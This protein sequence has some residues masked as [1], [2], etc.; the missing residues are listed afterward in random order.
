MSDQV[1]KLLMGTYFYP[2]GGSAHVARALAGELGAQGIE[3]TLVSGSRAD[4]GPAADA[5]DFYA[6]LDVRAV[7]FTPA[8][9]SGRPL[10]FVGPAGTA[11]MHGSFED[12]ED[13]VD[14]V[15]TSLDDRRLELQV[16]AWARELERAAAGGVDRL[17][18]H[19]LTPLN[20]AA[21]R[22]LPG[23]PIVGHIP[24]T[25]LLMLAAIQAG[26]G[27]GGRG[28]VAWIKRLRRW[29]AACERLIVADR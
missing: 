24:G 12:R 8:L 25:Q 23:V 22:A 5:K 28:G 17:Y 11:P 4:L 13:A 15:L 6:G 19:H 18:L 14:P 26:A 21:A 27:A 10:D 16:D 1:E 2:R 20:E 7:D 29:A 9:R 3:V